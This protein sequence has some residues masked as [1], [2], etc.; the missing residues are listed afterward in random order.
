MDRIKLFSGTVSTNTTENIKNS[1]GMSQTT[2]INRERTDV[3]NN[4]LVEFLDECGVEVKYDGN[5]LWINGVP[6]VF[7][8]YQNYCFYS[9]YFPFNSTAVVKGSSTTTDIFD[10]NNNYNFKVRLLGEPTRAFYL[11]I[12]RNCTS[13]AFNQVFGFFK[14]INFLSGR[15]SVLYRYGAS[16]TIYAVDIDKDGLPVD[17]GRNTENAIASCNLNIISADYSNNPDKYPLVEWTPAIF[18]VEGCYYG[19]PNSPLPSAS[20]QTAD[21]QTFIKLGDEVY[22]MSYQGPLIK[23]TS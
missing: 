5:Y 1:Y 21:A 4:A 13:P 6:I 11:V 12:S 20:G 2:T 7:H 9:C 19:L 8:F 22:Y 15:E 16:L 10:N 3:L 14:A 23:C 18:K 17:I